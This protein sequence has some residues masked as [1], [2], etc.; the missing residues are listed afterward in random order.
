MARTFTR[1]LPMAMASFVRNTSSVLKNFHCEVEGR[2]R[3]SGTGIAGLSTLQQQATIYE[4][5]FKDLSA[6]AMNQIDTR[7]KD[8]NREFIRFIEN[9]MSAAYEQC[10]NER[11]KVDLPSSMI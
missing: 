8:I 2:A 9:A 5:L 1:R 10:V 7:Q 3:K 11:G 6:T 4:A